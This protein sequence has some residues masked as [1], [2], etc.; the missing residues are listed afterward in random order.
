MTTEAAA[1]PRI[2]EL[3]LEN[4]FAVGVPEQP[5]GGQRHR[6]GPGARWTD[7]RVAHTLDR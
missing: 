3:L 7:R 4:L 2:H 5:P 6:R 1:E